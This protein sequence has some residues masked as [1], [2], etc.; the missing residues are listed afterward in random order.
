MESSLFPTLMPV[1]AA[2]LYFN[3]S[4]SDWN[5]MKSQSSFNIHSVNVKK[6]N[7]KKKTSETFVFLFALFL[8]VSVYFYV[9]DF[10]WVVF[11]P[12]V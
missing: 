10:N 4:Y 3:I 1:F 2:F 12:G 9:P 8:E 5:N 6:V 7:I 11:I